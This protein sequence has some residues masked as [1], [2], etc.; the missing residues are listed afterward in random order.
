M[1]HF[2]T[3]V[4]LSPARVNPSYQSDIIQEVQSLLERYDAQ[5][6]VNVREDDQGKLVPFNED[7]RWV[8]YQ[9][10]GEFSRLV[11]PDN[12]WAYTSVDERRDLNE[13]IINVDFIL[14][15]DRLDKWTPAALVTPSGQWLE[16]SEPGMYGYYKMDED[17]VWRE[18]VREQLIK[19]K[20]CYAVGVD[21]AI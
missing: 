14:G 3:V 13:N 18:K 7:A 20:D 9:I 21:C 16:Q 19:Y 1:H 17:P 8:T 4:L 11:N 10:G 6:E 12:M 2:F 15:S 5:K